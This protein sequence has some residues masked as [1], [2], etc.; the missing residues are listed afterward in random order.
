MENLGITLQD[1]ANF[2]S[3]AGNASQAEL[4]ELIKAMSAGSITGRETTGLTTASGAPLKTESLETTLK[5]LTN[6]ERDIVFWKMIPKLPAYN[7]VEEYNQLKSYGTDGGAFTNEGELPESAD[8]QY[9][10]RAELVKF[11]GV[12][13]EVTHPMQLV[14]TMVGNMIQKEIQNGTQWLLRQVD[15]AL[16]FG[17]AANVPQEFNGFYAQH[18]TGFEG[19]ADQ[20]QD[21]EVVIDARGY[22]LDDA[23]V[24]SAASG[25]NVNYGFADKIIAPPVIFSNYVKGFHERKLI[26]PNTQQVQAGIMGQKVVKIVTQFGDIDV[27]DDKF[28]R[29]GSLYRM[30]NSAALSV[31]APAAIVPDGV[32]PLAAV[33]DATNRFKGT[34]AYDGDYFYA[35]APKNRYGEGTLTPL[36]N[37]VVAIATTESADLKFADGGGA[38]PATSYVVYR[39]E[40]DP[41]G[42]IGV[43]PLYPIFEISK[44]EVAAGYDGADPGLVR[45]KN[46]VIANTESAIVQ[47]HSDQ[48]YAFKQ[49]APLMKMDLAILAPSTRFMI[50]LYGT[51]ILY[52]PKKWAKIINIGT[53]VK[54]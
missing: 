5:V 21:S 20:Y 36:S 15:N 17:K 48:V 54:A 37:A 43:T 27:V 9:V 14:S 45:D 8:S 26:Q 3:G 44:A 50:L 35:V 12:T 33:A 47:E 41:A 52:A 6:T 7:T 51:P 19:T 39:S 24:E 4:D 29:K 25:V 34:P 53:K 1:Y 49:L 22:R 23:F 16:F 13:R 2:G 18:F 10:R 31:K 46:R 28:A 32:T 38:Y 42:A 11:L 40:V 30:A